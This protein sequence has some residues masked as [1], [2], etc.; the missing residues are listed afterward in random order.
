M[1]TTKPCVACNGADAS[2]FTLWLD[3]VTDALTLSIP[4]YR[5]R[6]Y[7]FLMSVAES[8]L[9]GLGRITF[10]F[11]RALGIASLSDDVEKAVSNRSKLLWKEAQRR[12]IQMQQMMLFG[13]PTDMFVL[14]HAG[15]R[16][17]FQSLPLAPE[18]SALR[19]DDKVLFKE[20][21]LRERLP[22]PKNFSARTLKQAREALKE[23]EVACVKPRTGSNGRHTYP[24]VKTDEELREA[25]ESVKQ[26]SAY[27][28]VEEYLEGNVCRATCVDSK[29]IG[30]LESA[31]PTII[32]D[33]TST[34]SE[35]IFAGNA[36]KKEGIGDMELSHAVLGFIKRKGYTPDSI[37]PEGTVLPLTYS[38]GRSLGGSNREH[39]R[40][41]HPSFIEPIE[42]AAKLTGLHIVGFD[43]IV[44]DPMQPADSQHWGFIESN[45]LPWID[46]HATPYYGEPV[47]LSPAVWDLWLTKVIKA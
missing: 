14:R 38:A 18:A 29:L 35:L 25:F 12:D 6:P 23:I 10:L 17:F 9:G 11:G 32:G 19:M 8:L 45:S 27:A 34:I 43:L 33:G 41:I 44:P 15:K 4:F 2:H 5:T 47:D 20:M 22:V 37:L 46:L 13:K 40:T 36:Q 24:N 3:T 21:M 28:S 31:Y 26:I 30:F 16:H 42:R 1:A 39:G 7:R